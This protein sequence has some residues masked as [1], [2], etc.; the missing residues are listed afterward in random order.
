MGDTERKV[1]E[2]SFRRKYAGGDVECRPSGADALTN[3]RRIVLLIHGYNNTQEEACKSYNNFLKYQRS[4]AGVDCNE[5]V[6]PGRQFVKVYWPGDSTMPLRFLYYFL[7]AIP[8]AVEAAGCLADVLIDAVRK[9]GP[10]EIEIV[11]HSMGCRLAFELLRHLVGAEGIT[12]KHV[13]FMAAA[14]ETARLEDASD[15]SDFRKAYDIILKDGRTLNMFSQLDVVLFPVFPIG[16]RL[17]RDNKSKLPV[18]LGHKRWVSKNTPNNMEQENQWPNGHGDYWGD[19]E[20]ETKR[21]REV[22]DKISKFLQFEGVCAREPGYREVVA[23]A[24]GEVRNP[25]LTRAVKPRSCGP[26]EKYR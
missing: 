4:I 9:S 2:L 15:P 12:V 14:A 16:E 5:R 23:R 3:N 8:N 6:A 20:K 26:C 25:S 19:P 17:A 13:V 21:T 1:V 7:G 10:K 18:A 22:N 24:A 11:S